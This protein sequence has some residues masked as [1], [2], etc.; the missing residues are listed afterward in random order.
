MEALKKAREARG[1]EHDHIAGFVGLSRL[2]YW[3]AESYP[4]EA[5]TLTISQLL[6]LCVLLD[7]PPRDLVHVNWTAP[8]APFAPFE[9]GS[10]ISASLHERLAKVPNIEEDVGWDAKAIEKWLA[11][12]AALGEMPLPALGDLCEAT[13]TDLVEVLMVYWDA[14][15]GGTQKS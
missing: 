10:D 1:I 15:A 3:D 13:D 6:R 9:T 7:L 5:Y 4:D 14:L 12:D 11:D 8:H 2:W